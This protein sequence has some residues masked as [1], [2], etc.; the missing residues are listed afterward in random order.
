[1]FYFPAVCSGRFSYLHFG[2]DAVRDLVAELA[3]AGVRLG[4][5]E[6]VGQGAV[7]WLHDLRRH[8]GWVWE[9]REEKVMPWK[10]WR[11]EL[12]FVLALFPLVFAKQS[13]CFYWPIF[14]F[15]SKVQYVRFSTI[16]WSGHTMQPI[17][18][19]FRWMILLSMLHWWTGLRC[20]WT[21]AVSLTH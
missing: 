2:I 5:Q 7:L 15:V 13:R 10:V 16:Q 14:G 17:P 9:R 20:V 6:W 3:G 12:K 19:D 1:M 11:S 4:Q 18:E 8:R 21:M